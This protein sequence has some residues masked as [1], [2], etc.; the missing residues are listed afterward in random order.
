[1][2]V[3]PDIRKEKW[4]AEEDRHLAALVAEHGNRWADIAKKCVSSSYNLLR[5]HIH[6]LCTLVYLEEELATCI[7][8]E[9][10]HGSVARTCV[11]TSSNDVR[12]SSTISSSLAI[13]QV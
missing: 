3:N 7:S 1:L 2:Q 12:E 9:S 10:W 4:S 8:E 13:R 6:Q 5:E 11:R